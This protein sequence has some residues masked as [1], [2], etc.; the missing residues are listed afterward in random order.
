MN[1]NLKYDEETQTVTTEVQRLVLQLQELKAIEK[2]VN[3][4]YSQLKV[5]L[6]KNKYNKLMRKIAKA[7]R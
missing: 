4:E 1:E 6:A 2:N 5:K 7:F 3:G